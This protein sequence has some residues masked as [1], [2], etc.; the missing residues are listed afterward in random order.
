MCGGDPEFAAVYTGF[1][2]YG[3]MLLF[4][5]TALTFLGRPLE[6]LREAERAIEI[7]RGRKDNEL[8]LM[9]H[10]GFVSACEAIGDAAGALAHARQAVELAEGTGG[11]AWAGAALPTLGRAQ[12]LNGE[13]REAA[14]SLEQ[15]LAT[16][17]KYR[18]GLISEGCDARVPGG[19]VSDRRRCGPRPRDRRAGGGH[20]PPAAHPG[21]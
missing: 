6:A 15:A 7:A 4:R 17:R 16:T 3:L 8:Q 19:G 11:P 5:A 9:S 10:T 2:P 13:G 18:T 21:L 12:L 14:T 1:S 20:S